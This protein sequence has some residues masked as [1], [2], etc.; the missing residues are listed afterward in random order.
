MLTDIKSMTLEELENFIVK[1]GF[2]KFRAKQIHGWIVKS[3]K[4]CDK[5]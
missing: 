3:V 2:P 1:N 4:K 5:F